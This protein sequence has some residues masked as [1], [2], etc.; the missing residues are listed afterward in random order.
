MVWG[1][2]G[3]LFGVAEFFYSDT[4]WTLLLF[5]DGILSDCP[6]LKLIILPDVAVG[7]VEKLLVGV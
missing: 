4:S 1:A 2:N 3:G 5:Q 7:F 6:I